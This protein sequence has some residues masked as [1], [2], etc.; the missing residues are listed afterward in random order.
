MISLQAQ[1]LPP[2]ESYFQV[3]WT[4][5][6]VLLILIPEGYGG[7]QVPGGKLIQYSL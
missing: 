1:I 4:F 3:L 5:V 2:A 6:R 7:Q